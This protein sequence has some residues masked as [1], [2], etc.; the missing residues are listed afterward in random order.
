MTSFAEQLDR[1]ASL[2]RDA[3]IAKTSM[4]L[5]LAK[6]EIINLRSNAIAERDSIKLSNKLVVGW[7][8]LRG[9]RWERQ[10]HPQI[11]LLYT[12]PSPRDS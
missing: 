10:L 3:L 7:R 9:A 6:M 8:R 5:I 4:S 1:M 2:H 11:C 12:S